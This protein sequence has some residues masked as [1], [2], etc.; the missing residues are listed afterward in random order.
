MPVLM[1]H[2][3]PLDRRSL[4]G[5]LGALVERRGRYRQLRVDLPGFGSSPGVSEIASSDDMVDFVVA[6]VDELIGAQQVLVVGESWGAYLARA[7]V[8]RR[9]DQ[10][11]G[12]ALICPVVIATHERRDVPPQELLFEEPGLFGGEAGANGSVSADAEEVAA[13][14]EIAVRADRAAWDHWRSRILP[15]LNAA[16][17][18]A[19]ARIEARYAFEQDV[20]AVG[21]PFERPSL[22]VVGRQDG[23]VGYRDAVRLVERF[24][25]S[26]FAILDG[27]GHNLVGER[28]GLVEALVGDWLDRVEA[29]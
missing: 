21:P 16:D 3:F 27:G 5:S 7:V 19:L 28:P 10:V 8:A 11:A 2:G 24:P 4:A 20:D 15:A 6:L 9:A 22:I 29:S 18:E 26:T 14:R 1:L 25:R 13:F 12:V 17:E 23:V